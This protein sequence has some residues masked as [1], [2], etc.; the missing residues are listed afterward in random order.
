MR[1]IYFEDKYFNNVVELLKENENI[2]ILSN[3]TLDSWLHHLEK[4][5]VYYDSSFYKD[6]ELYNKYVSI[7][8]YPGNHTFGWDRGI[9]Y[10][11]NVKT[12]YFKQYFKQA[13]RKQ[14][15]LKLCTKDIIKQ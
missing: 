14:K 5:K 13:F 3:T 15:L 4:E 1:I 11:N 10:R 12:F 7:Y 8:L 9:R 2:D 6:R